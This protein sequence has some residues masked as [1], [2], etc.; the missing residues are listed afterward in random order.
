MSST[1]KKPPEVTTRARDMRRSPT[2]AE[3]ILWGVLRNRQIEG[4]KF[5]RQYPITPYIVDFCCREKKLIIEV[6]GGIHIEQEMYDHVRDLE[7]KELGYQIIR[8]TN[9]DV[10]K[11]VHA[12][13]TAI[14]EALNS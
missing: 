3:K 13:F 6:D 12:V 14:Q 5:V 8:F 2:P 10:S 9:D 4:C 7:L 1:Q 11:N